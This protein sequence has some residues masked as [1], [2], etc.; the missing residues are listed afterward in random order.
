MNKI[1]ESIMNQLNIFYQCKKYNVPLRQCPQFLFFVMGN[2]IIATTIGTYYIGT[3]FNSDPEVVVLVVIAL[4]MV[5]LV[6]SFVIVQSFEQLAETSRL[7]TEFV[8]IVSHQIRSPLTNLKW[9]VEILMSGILSK[10][11]KKQEEYFK[12]LKENLERMQTLVSELLT[13]SRIEAA[14]FVLKKEEFSLENLA[15]DLVSEFE[16]ITKSSN[17][18]IGVISAPGLPKIYGDPFQILQVFENLLYNAVRYI[19][20]TADNNVDKGQGKVTIKLYRKGKY[21]FCEVQDN[22]IGIPK[23]DHKYIFQKFFRAENVRRYQTSGSGL[24]LY[25]SKNIIEKSGGKMGFTSCEGVGTT[26]WLKLPIASG[27]Q[28]GKLKNQI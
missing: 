6:I 19:G 15:R 26:F 24:G 17:I 7:K 18:K 12:I 8:S 22:G 5:L 2:A 14:K 27:D 16:S 20:F 10:T 9:I 3:Y 28:N 1:L 23:N 13:V 4:A 25:I 11:E 21:V